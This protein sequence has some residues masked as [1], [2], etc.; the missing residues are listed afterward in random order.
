VRFAGGKV[1]TTLKV[2]N[3]FNVEAQQHVFGDILK[4]RVAGEV[5]IGF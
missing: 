4:R 2:N 5:K 3:M 1:T